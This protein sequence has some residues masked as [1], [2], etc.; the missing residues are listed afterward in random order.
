MTED[1]ERTSSRRPTT[2]PARAH[3]AR[4][5]RGIELELEDQLATFERQGKLLEAQRLRMRTTYDIEMM[6]RSAPARASR[7]TRCTSTAAPGARRPTPARLLPPDFSSSSTRAA[8]PIPQIGGMYEGD[9]SR[10]RNLVDTVSG[11][12]SARTTAR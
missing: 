2:S 12:P 8:Q 4:A 5:I 3:G 6:R 7:T 1:E 9:M 11:L 10:K